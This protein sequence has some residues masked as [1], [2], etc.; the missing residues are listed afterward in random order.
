MERMKLRAI[1]PFLVAFFFAAAPVFASAASQPDFSAFTNNL[2]RQ[3]EQLEKQLGL[4]PV[5]KD[6][7]VAAVTATKR[8][9]LQ[10]TMAGMQAKARLEEELAKPRPDLGVLWELR[11]SIVED[12]KT[13]RREAREE[14]SKL[15]AMLD[16]DQVATFK[17]FIEERVENLG[18]LHDFLLQ[19]VLTPRERT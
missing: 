14:W 7:Y 17:R 15:Y 19:L 13:L 9:L 3:L 4:T 11:Q 16:A 5:Q 18:L 12:S 10:M 6:Q 1:V 2:N 8:L